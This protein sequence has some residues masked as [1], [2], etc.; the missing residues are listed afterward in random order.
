[1]AKI[2]D[3]HAIIVDMDESL[4]DYGQTVLD[5]KTNI[6]QAI[7]DSAKN[8]INNLD[9]LFNDQGFGRQDKF[10]DIG[11]G[12]LKDFE[13]Q[14][15]QQLSQQSQLLAEEALEYLGKHTNEF[16]NWRK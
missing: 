11:V 10:Y 15:E 16:E 5:A 14:N 12:Y 3:R 4:I 2:I 6:S 7:Y 8:D 9:K 13:P 1:M